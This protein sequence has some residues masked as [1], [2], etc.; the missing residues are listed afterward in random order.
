MTRR[1]ARLRRR[2]KRMIKR[3]LAYLVLLCIVVGILYIGAKLLLGNQVYKEYK[4]EAGSTVEASDLFKKENPGA[5]FT[6][7]SGTIDT[8]KPGTYPV[9]VTNGKRVYKCD[10]KV[11]D[12]VAP[13]AKTIPVKLKWGETCSAEEMVTEVV[14]ATEVRIMFKNEPDFQK[15]GAQQVSVLIS[16][17]GNNVSELYAELTILPKD[18]EPPV[19]EGARDLEFTMGSTATYRKDIV[20]TD[21]SGDEV[22][23]EIDST[24]VILDQEGA[25]P[26]TYT[27]TDASGNSSSV[28]VT[29]YISPESY[30]VSEVY[31]L[32]D[33]VI[34]DIITEDMTGYDKI[35][36]IFQYI[37]KNVG[38]INHSE[39]INWVQGAYEGLVNKQGDC[40]VYACI[41][42]VLLDRAGIKNM[43]IEKIPAK[44]QH[45]WN[46]VD[47]GEG[48]YHF[49]TTPRVDH[50]T[51]FYWDDATL[52]EYSQKHNLSHNYDH[53]CYP[54]VQ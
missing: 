51:I 13:T 29:V 42:K 21:N 15:E 24:Q 26:L 27:A 48:W 28:T 7:N 36:A 41:S 44:S 38:Y 35:W 47:I 1:E 43:D 33:K 20:L 34:A 22:E 4:V 40:Y 39:K 2:R 11:V 10:V 9:K 8:H 30:S 23:L 50:P 18:T 25:Y 53:D 49:D 3:I 6:E 52:M 17:Q 45:F 12:T 37:R 32:A 5:L 54:K 14:D 19:I 46:L 31:A 16:D